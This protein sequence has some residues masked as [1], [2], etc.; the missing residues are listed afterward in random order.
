MNDEI[1]EEM[2]LN[3]LLG[4]QTSLYSM[5]PEIHDYITQIKGSFEKTM[6]SILKLIEQDIPLQ[7]SCPILKQNKNC[8]SEVVNWAKNQGVYAGDDY[9]IIARYNNSTQNLSCRLS[10]TEIEDVII[11]K[12]KVDENYI[13]NIKAE[14][15]Q[16]IN[17]SP[18]D[19][20]CSVCEYTLCIGENGNVYPC[21]GWQNYVV[22]NILKNSLQEIWEKSEKVNYLRNLRKKEI[23]KCLECPDKEYCTMCMVRNANENPNGDPLVVNEYFCDIAKLIKRIVVD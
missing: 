11:E 3:P 7:I 4:V 19:Y 9:I 21:A 20:V 2:K 15:E 6:S 18:D 12:S 10:I 13:K 22:G 1:I 17:Y 5:K 16:S 23:P 14:A 8:Y